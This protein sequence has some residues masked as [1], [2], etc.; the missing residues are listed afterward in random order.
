MNAQ[1]Q[2]RD[3]RKVHEDQS[4]CTRQRAAYNT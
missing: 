3:R 4:L 2:P 1:N